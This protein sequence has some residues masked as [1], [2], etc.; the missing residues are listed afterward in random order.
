MLFRLSVAAALVVATAPA[1]AQP[2]PKFEFAKA[3][4]VAKVKDVE[5][6][7]QA[8]AGVIFTTGNSE[9]TTITAGIRAARKTGANKLSLEGSLTY[10]KSGLRV[11]DDIN[12]N[13]MIDDEAEITTVTTT[14]AETLAGKLRYDRFLTAANSLFVAALASRDLPAG[15]ESA[16]GAQAGYM[17]QLFKDERSEAVAEI[18]YDFSRE[19]LVTGASLSIHSARAFVGYKSEMTAGATLEASAEALTNLNEETLATGADGGP[20]KDTRVIAKVAVSA[21]IGKNLAVQ[22]AI[23]ARYDH[24]PG[25]LAIKGLAMGFVPEASALDTT[26]KASLIYTFF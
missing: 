8:E 11:I 20:G 7:A 26:M 4:E 12:G 10:A 18:G 14:T 24:R 25:P 1:L 3:D 9:T 2:T 22:T 15:K 6:N 21:K 5:W 17:R 13:G 19:D 16:Y 23:E